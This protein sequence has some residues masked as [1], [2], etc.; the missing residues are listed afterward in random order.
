MI[1]AGHVTVI[2]GLY[3]L[4]QQDNT[5]V[6]DQTSRMACARNAVTGSYPSALLRGPRHQTNRVGA[7]A[8]LF[9][10]WSGVTN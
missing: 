2:T 7:E 8:D 3:G 9:L 10:L 1:A 4:R 5:L 6:R